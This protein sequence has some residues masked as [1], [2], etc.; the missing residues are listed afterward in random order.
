[1]SSRLHSLAALAD[2]TVVGWGADYSGQISAPALRSVS[3]L[4]AGRAHSLALLGPAVAL[5]APIFE[6]QPP[7]LTFSNGAFQLRL[8]NLTGQGISVI[9][10]STNLVDWEPIH[11]NVPKPGSLDFVDP[12]SASLPQRFYRAYEQR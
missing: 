6:L 3:A 1:M 8:S 4:S 12:G 2:G 9:L 10:A 11:Y 5:P 7:S